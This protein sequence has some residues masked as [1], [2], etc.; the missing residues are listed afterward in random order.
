MSKCVSCGNKIGMFG[1]TYDCQAEDCKIEGLCKECSAAK[2]SECSKC[3]YSF[4]VNHIKN[5]EC[6]G[7]EEK[8]EEENS[9]ESEEDNDEELSEDDVFVSKGKMFKLLTLGDY[10]Y[11]ESVMNFLE[12]TEKDGYVLVAADVS[13]STYL[14]K[15]EL[16]Q[17]SS[18][19]KSGES[20]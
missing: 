4:C 1:S 10:E 7:E 5:H 13:N 15:K 3:G 20:I 18:I 17:K 9:E 12:E 16:F 8:S 6:E 14:F 19:K 2:L 11:Y